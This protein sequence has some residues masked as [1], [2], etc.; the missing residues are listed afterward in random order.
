MCLMQKNV[1]DFNT[2]EAYKRCLEEVTTKYPDK[3]IYGWLRY[4]NF[5]GDNWHKRQFHGWQTEKK[6]RIGL[7]KLRKKVANVREGRIVVEVR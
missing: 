5:W 4:Q 2:E 6:N 3:Y 7:T 1:Y